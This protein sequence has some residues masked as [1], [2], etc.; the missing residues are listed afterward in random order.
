M[1]QPRSDRRDKILEALV[2]M[3]E[4]GPETKI[5]TAN[6]ARAVGVSEAALY[7]HF[8]SKTKMFEALIEFIEEALFSRIRVINNEPLPALERCNRILFLLLGFCERNPGLTRILQ[9]E[10]LAGE[11]ERLHQRVEQLFD[12]IETQLRGILRQAELDEQMRTSMPLNEAV[13]TIM[14]L[15]EGRINQFVRSRFNR[16]PTLSW[17][18]QWGVITSRMMQPVPSAQPI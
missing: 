16:L 4:N 17:A 18:E 15:A 1:P 10:A 11:S 13:T 9:G 6:L 12:R 14:A 2:T 5:T 7:R 8:A 3:L